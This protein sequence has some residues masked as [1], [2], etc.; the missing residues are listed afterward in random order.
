MEQ[1]FLA[2]DEQ[3]AGGPEKTVQRVLFVDDDQSVLDSL[4]Q[5]L[6]EMQAEW[7]MTLVP[8]AMMRCGCSPHVNFTSSLPIWECQA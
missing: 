8:A 3:Q 2:E 5:A 7:Q 1:L 4:K 6:H